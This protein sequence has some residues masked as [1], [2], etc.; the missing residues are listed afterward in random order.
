MYVHIK[1][2]MCKLSRRVTYWLRLIFISYYYYY[3][4]YYS[5]HV[6]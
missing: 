3:Y 6:Y 4:Y 1:R 5:I 2:I